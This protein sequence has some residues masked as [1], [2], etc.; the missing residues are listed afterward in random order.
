VKENDRGGGKVERRGHGVA[1]KKPKFRLGQ[2]GL[3]TVQSSRKG[4]GG[5]CG[6]GAVPLRQQNAPAGRNRRIG[7]L[8]SGGGK[9]REKKVR[10]SHFLSGTSIRSSLKAGGHQFT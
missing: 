4:D 1:E 8:F 5:S 3:S 6:E 10:V 9:Q 7:E 2:N